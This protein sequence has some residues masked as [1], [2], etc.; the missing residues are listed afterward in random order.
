M[1][2]TVILT[3]LAAVTLG[4]A[5]LLYGR[6]ANIQSFTGALGGVAATPIVDS[7]DEDRPFLVAGATFVNI[8]AA[9]QRSCDQQQNGCF[10]LVNGAGDV[11]FDQADCA[12]QKQACDAAGGA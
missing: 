7:G 9:L 1:K 4:Q 12:A 8:G 2:T 3:L 5:R 11:D 10:N 6:Q